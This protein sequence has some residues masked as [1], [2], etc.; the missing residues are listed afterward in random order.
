M[1]SMSCDQLEQIR[2]SEST[3]IM[4]PLEPPVIVES[5]EPSDI[6]G[7]LEPLDIMQPLEALDIMQ[8]LE[9]SDIMRPLEASDIIEPLEPSDIIEP[10][11]PSDIISYIIHKEGKKYDVILK[12]SD[13]NEIYVHKSIL[14]SA[15]E[16]FEKMFGGGF[17]ESTQDVIEIKD[18]SV[19]V[20]NCLINFIYTKELD[21]INSDN[22]EEILNGAEFL[23]LADARV[24]CV[25]FFTEKL[26][27]DDN[28]LS[29]K[30]MAD[31]RDIT[32][33]S[34]NCIK[35][36]LSRFEFISDLPSFLDEVD[37]ELLI[38]LINDDNLNASYEVDVYTA[39]MDWVKH[40]LSDREYLLPGLL[41]LVRLVFIPTRHLI[42]EMKVE[43]LIYSNPECLELFNRVIDHYNF[44]YGD[45]LSKIIT[46]VRPRKNTKKF[47]YDTMENPRAVFKIPGSTIKKDTINLFSFLNLDGNNSSDINTAEWEA[48]MNE[49]NFTTPWYE[50]WQSLF[51]ADDISRDDDLI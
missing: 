12:T 1:I 50:G 9:A 42:N 16:Y 13:G 29:I 25:K 8:P 31:F 44:E 21:T 45:P 28:Y 20:L 39:V 26:M 47:I 49:I 7:P 24:E 41:S 32:E 4:E 37:I 46:G 43:P 5:L 48:G 38:Q 15:S 3:D 19:D 40:D 18:I 35:Y 34:Q 27:N 10:L 30:D 23:Q 17:Q 22:A 11:E 33:L 2:K 51:S 6:M 14:A 36:A